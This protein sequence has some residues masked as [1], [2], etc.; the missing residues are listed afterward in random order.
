M[1]LTI[2][3]TKR[4][5]DAYKV[6]DGAARVADRVKLTA[7]RMT[8]DNNG[9]WRVS[10]RLLPGM[11]RS[12]VKKIAPFWDTDVGTAVLDWNRENGGERAIVAGSDFITSNKEDAAMLR[13]AFA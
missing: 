10:F 11:K 6:V 4:P 3:R 12:K 2:R 1:I 5:R 9:R 7:Y 13:L 8:E